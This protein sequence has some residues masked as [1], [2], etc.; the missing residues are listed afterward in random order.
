MSEN[1]IQKE[2]STEEILGSIRR[3]ITEDNAQAGKADAP[4][5]T[6]YETTAP[7]DDMA[8][9]EATP[10]DTAPN[11]LTPGDTAAGD[12]EIL[13]LTDE[14][15]D[16][17]APADVQPEADHPS[18]EVRREPKFGL[19]AA[20]AYESGD[21]VRRE[22][23]IGTQADEAPS[24]EQPSDDQPQSDGTVPPPLQGYNYSPQVLS[25]TQDT[26]GQ[27]DYTMESTTE[28]EQEI[29]DTPDTAEA[30]QPEAE[31][32]GAREEIVS[33]TTTAATAAALGDLSRA[34][35]EKTGKLKLGGDTTVAEI[36]KEMLR[37]MLREWLDENLPLIV[38]RV[39]RREIQ[40]L[41]DRAQDDD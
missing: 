29:T 11:E 1:R 16:D 37:P 40:K 31:S 4:A 9:D 22:P 8:A 39:V 28:G 3:I 6:A 30:G 24:G 14:V 5:R 17:G 33:E 36:V 15:V 35:S 32:G 12:D 41:V 7:T 34:V 20:P 13:E 25:S 19:S 21:G 27:E 18:E 38:D 26:T 2:P 10:E 23:V